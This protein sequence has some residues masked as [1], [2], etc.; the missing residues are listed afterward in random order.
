MN[1]NTLLA[2]F[3]NGFEPVAPVLTGESNTNDGVLSNL[4]S[5]ISTG[6]GILTVLGGIFF[7]F[8]F[9][10][11]TYK[12]LTAGGDSAKLGQAWQQIIHG[13]LGLL[14]L[15]AGYAIVG[16]IGSIVGIEI[17]NPALILL[18]IAPIAPAGP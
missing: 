18:E 17:L 6:L 16:L 7:L 9:F 8:Y 13:V 3:G 2:Q 10:T 12:I 1:T 5:I 4:E 15:V 14:I 11:A